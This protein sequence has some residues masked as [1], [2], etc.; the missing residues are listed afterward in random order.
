M[1]PGDLVTTKKSREF[2]VPKVGI[3]IGMRTFKCQLSEK[4]P[5]QYSGG[6]YTCAEVMWFGHSAPN[7]DPVSSIQHDLIEVI[8]EGR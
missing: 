7:G 6:D 8:N 3:F 1:K 5:D 2:H 4:Y